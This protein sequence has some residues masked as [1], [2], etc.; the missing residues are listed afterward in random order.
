MIE[1]ITKQ[2]LIEKVIIGRADLEQIMARVPKEFIE[3][4]RTINDLSIRDIMARICWCEHKMIGLIHTHMLTD[5]EIF[6]YDE[7]KRN[8]IVMERVKGRPFSEIRA[9]AYQLIKNLVDA[10]ETMDKTDLL[11][12]S[13]YEGIP[14][15]VT[16]VAFIA[17]NTY[18]HYD[19]HCKAIEEWLDCLH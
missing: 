17:A 10:L 7:A 2:E 6:G 13:R 11:D 12:A 19:T 16:P 15:G 5:A 1:T 18:E 4:P 3:K 8:A 14:E 9:E